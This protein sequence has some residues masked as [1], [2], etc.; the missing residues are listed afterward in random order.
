MLPEP[1]GFGPCFT[2]VTKPM[3]RYLLGFE[4]AVL[5]EPQ[6]I[7]RGLVTGSAAERAGVRNGDAITKPVPQDMI[8]GQQDATLTLELL[9][10]GQPLTVTYLPRA[11]TVAAYQWIR[12]GSLPDSACVY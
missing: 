7:V 11:E 10:D 2:R 1:G 9:R 4:P 5:V 8:Q 3:R 12:T 6:R